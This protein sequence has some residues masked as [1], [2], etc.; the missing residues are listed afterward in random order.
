M[1]MKRLAAL[2]AATVLGGS[3]LAA[4]AAAAQPGTPLCPIYDPSSI[5]CHMPPPDNDPDD[6]PGN[7]RSLDHNF[8]R[9]RDQG[10]R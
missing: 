4:G 8:D 7:G 5:F 2:S 6:Q 3:V 9:D 10:L 1:R